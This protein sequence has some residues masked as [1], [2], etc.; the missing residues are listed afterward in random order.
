VNRTLEK[1][2]GEIEWEHG[3][4]TSLTK[5]AEA[6]PQET[7]TILRLYLLDW[8]LG[9]RQRP[10]F[11][12]DDVKSAL[13]YLYGNADTK[14]GTESLINDLIHKGGKPYWVLKKLLGKE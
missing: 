4:V 12:R 11:M 2:G 14:A 3:L 13:G 6:A 1:T 7:L 9:G 5:L 8:G 10:F